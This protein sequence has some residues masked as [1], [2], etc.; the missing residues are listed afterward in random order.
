MQE[1]IQWLLLFNRL[2]IQNI[3][4]RL[5]R[6][7]PHLHEL[8][9][10]VAMFECGTWRKQRK[11]YPKFKNLVD[12]TCH[13]LPCAVIDNDTDGRG[14]GARLGST[15]QYAGQAEVVMM[16]M[17]ISQGQP[18]RSAELGANS[19]RCEGKVKLLENRDPKTVQSTSPRCAPLPYLPHDNRV[20]TT[21]TQ[22]AT[23]TP[24]SRLLT[25]LEQPLPG[26]N[27]GKPC[28]CFVTVI[29]MDVYIKMAHAADQRRVP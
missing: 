27:G 26:P 20:L 16:G 28:T 13:A 17:L 3:E 10:N 5:L 7:I 24:A 12:A 22:W 9:Y 6:Q 11:C 4:A 1:K 2:R 23:N 21:S 14:L 19:A 18:I 25:Y 29:R 8:G 15:L